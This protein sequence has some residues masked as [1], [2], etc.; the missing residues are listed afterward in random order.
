MRIF[1]ICCIARRLG[2]VCSIPIV[3][4]IGT[5]VGMKSRATRASAYALIVSHFHS[6]V[7]P[8]ATLCKLKWPPRTPAYPPLST[9]TALDLIPRARTGQ[10]LCTLYALC[11]HAHRRPPE[12]LCV[13]LVEPSSSALAGVAG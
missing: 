13:E 8:C 4:V 3:E 2:G 10:L 9:P 11:M 5:T 12:S 7:P 1:L 6:T